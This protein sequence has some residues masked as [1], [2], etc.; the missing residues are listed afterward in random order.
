MGYMRLSAHPSERVPL[1]RRTRPTRSAQAGERAAQRSA[2]KAGIVQAP[3]RI[4]IIADT[5]LPRGSRALPATFVEQLRA[6]DLIV[7]AGDFVARSAYDEVVALG[8]P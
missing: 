8:S 6:A 7:H 2:R 1:P 4:A 3:M 5:H